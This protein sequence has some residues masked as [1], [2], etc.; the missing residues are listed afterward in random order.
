KNSHDDGDRG[1]GVGLAII[2][3]GRKL[4]VLQLLGR[5]LTRRQ[6]QHIA[7]TIWSTRARR[8]SSTSCSTTTRAEPTSTTIAEFAELEGAD[9]RA[10]AELEGVGLLTTTTSARAGRSGS[11]L[12]QRARR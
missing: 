5:A 2:W 4:D 1:T 10:S 9:L 7:P 3:R 11:C 6:T 12:A 8:S